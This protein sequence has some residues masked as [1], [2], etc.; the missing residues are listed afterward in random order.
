M[1]NEGGRKGGKRLQKV[2]DRGDQCSFVFWF[3]RRSLFDVFPFPP[4]ETILI[5][6][7]PMIMQLR[8]IEI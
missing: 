5:G 3:C 6:D 2:P 8:G 1:K 7:V 4:S